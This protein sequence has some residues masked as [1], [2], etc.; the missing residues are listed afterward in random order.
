MSDD[1]GDGVESFMGGSDSSEGV[2]DDGGDGVE[3]SMRGSDPSACVSDDG[4]DGVEGSESL[5]LVCLIVYT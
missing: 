2:G 5:W 1:D 3:G 4:G